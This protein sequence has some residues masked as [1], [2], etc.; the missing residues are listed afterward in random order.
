[1]S[2]INV[3]VSTDEQHQQWRVVHQ[4]GVAVPQRPKSRHEERLKT[5][6]ATKML[7]ALKA[8]EQKA[9]PKNHRKTRRA[10]P[11]STLRLW[12]RFRYAA[13]RPGA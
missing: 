10:P 4:Y 2:V 7:E 8:N 11:S 3:T 1:M 12:G 5:A 9:T 6:K 13:T